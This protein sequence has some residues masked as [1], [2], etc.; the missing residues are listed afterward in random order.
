MTKI[1]DKKRCQ[2]CGS[3]NLETS[4]VKDEVSDLTYLYYHCKECDALYRFKQKRVVWVTK[5]KSK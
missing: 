5:G 2:W 3:K 4:E 1:A